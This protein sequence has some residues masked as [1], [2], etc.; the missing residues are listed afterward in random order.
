MAYCLDQRFEPYTD[1]YA[2]L[3]FDNADTGYAEV[4]VCLF[5]SEITPSHDI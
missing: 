4:S 3:F 5:V 2:E 1:R